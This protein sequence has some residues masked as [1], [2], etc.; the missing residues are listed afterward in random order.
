[1]DLDKD[2]T[3]CRSPVAL[4]PSGSGV[5]LL[6]AQQTAYFLAQPDPSSGTFTFKIKIP[7][8]IHSK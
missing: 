6:T 3:A 2:L 7:E 4:P 8:E 5:L 1:M